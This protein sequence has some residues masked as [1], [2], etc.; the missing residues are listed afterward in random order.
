MV[1]NF[2]PSLATHPC[3]YT[4]FLFFMGS[5]LCLYLK[6]GFIQGR[7]H[8]QPLSS[9]QKFYLCNSLYSQVLDAENPKSIGVLIPKRGA[10]ICLVSL[11]PI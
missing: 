2:F 6:Y 1:N 4:F 8:F 5:L 9:F 10:L 3:L 7:D 11:H